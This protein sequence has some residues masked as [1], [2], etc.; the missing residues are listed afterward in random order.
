MI[1][2]TNTA[3]DFT[4]PLREMQYNFRGDPVAWI[5]LPDCLHTA[6]ST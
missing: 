6:D 1:K 3:A 2:H 4:Y 5:Q